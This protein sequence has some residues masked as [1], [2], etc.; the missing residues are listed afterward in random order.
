MNARALALIGRPARRDVIR[1]AIEILVVA[2][3]YWAGARLGLSVAYSNRNVTAVWPPTGI[4]VAACFL[5]GRR[6]W[7]AIFL[8]AFVANM[9]NGAGFET[10]AGIA[11]GNTLAPVVAA[12]ILTRLG[13]HAALDRVGDI[14]S[15]GAAGLLAMTVSATL[16]TTVLLLTGMLDGPYGSSWTVWWFGDWMGVVVFAPA[17]LTVVAARDALRMPRPRLSEALAFLVLMPAVAFIL[18]ASAVPVWYLAIPLALLGALRFRQPVAAIT[19]AVIATASVIAMINGLGPFTGLS[20]TTRLVTLQLFN[21]TLALTV[22][23]LTALA[24]ERSR[25]WA[26]LKAAALDLEERVRVRSEEL[27]E[28]QRLI[29]EANA[30]ESLNLRA[31]VQRITKLERLKSDFLRL[32]SHEL[33]GPVGV[34]R[35]YVQMLSDGTLGTVPDS[36]QPAMAVL[37]TKADDMGR[38]VDQ[39]LETARLEKEDPI[40]KHELFDMAALLR[41]AV[42]AATTIVGPRH[43]FVLDDQANAT[44]VLADRDQVATI[45]T[46]LLDN[47]VRYSPDGCEV[48]ARLET[49]DGTVTVAVTDSGVG[50]ASDDVDRLFKSFSRIVTPDNAGIAGTG[51]GLYISRK[52]AVL[53]GGDLSVSSSTPGKGSTFTLTLPLATDAAVAEEDTETGESSSGTP[54]L[55]GEGDAMAAPEC[56]AVP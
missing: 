43:S 6:I 29:A 51:L 14:I 7:P 39:M 27:V 52:L 42:N 15:L 41:T 28:A 38:L 20:D 35:G 25:A 31:A 8:G 12:W 44:P 16:G 54:P 49:D 36:M 37:E 4:A 10:S 13:F 2:T 33:R 34:I 32:A 46:N 47:A 23:L 9:T 30:R 21:A 3:L 53:N 40:A 19:V 26:D 48:H 1:L 11:V 22:M 17:F 24:D 55:D 45:L 18:V 50:I 56:R 5:F